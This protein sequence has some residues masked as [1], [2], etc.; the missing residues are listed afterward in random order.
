MSFSFSFHFNILQ[1]ILSV[2]DIL[3]KA[4]KFIVDCKSD[5]LLLVNQKQLTAQFNFIEARSSL[6]KFEF[7]LPDDMQ[8]GNFLKVIT[9]DD[10]SPIF[11]ARF[12][13]FNWLNHVFKK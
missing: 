11:V 10:E 2:D 5:L 4:E 6:G 3:L 1:L 12:F 13:S 8:K 7:T 9:H